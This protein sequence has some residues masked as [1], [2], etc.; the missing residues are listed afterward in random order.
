MTI[1]GCAYECLDYTI[2]DFG[3]YPV[4][5]PKT[6]KDKCLGCGRCPEV[7]KTK[8]ITIE[9]K[10]A[11]IDENV[12]R[13]CGK[14]FDH[15]PNDAKDIKFEGYQIYVGGRGV[16]GLVEGCPVEVDTEEEVLDTLNK[17]LDLMKKYSVNSYERLSTVMKRVGKEKFMEELNY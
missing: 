9:D 15:C 17:V 1:G 14:C 8:A 4:K 5:Y 6:N 11:V 7:C 10:L 12:C 3:V 16:R 13:G 2:N